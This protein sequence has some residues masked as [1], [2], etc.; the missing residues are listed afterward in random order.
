MGEEERESAQNCGM[1]K[2]FLSETWL[3]RGVICALMETGHHTSRVIRVRKQMRSLL[4]TALEAPLQFFPPLAK[5][6]FCPE[7]DTWLLFSLLLSFA[8]VGSV[9]F[10]LS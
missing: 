7:P 10:P 8:P 4:E 9:G 6:F 5:I 3:L 1:L 2:L